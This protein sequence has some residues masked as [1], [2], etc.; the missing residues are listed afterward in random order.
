MQRRVWLWFAL[1]F[2]GLFLFVG[3]LTTRA[4]SVGPTVEDRVV[5]AA[6]IQLLL[7]GGDRFLAAD[8]EAIRSLAS[9]PGGGDDDALYRIRAHSAVA[10]LN[11]CHEDNYYTGNAL[12]TWGGAV[13]EGNDILLRAM[14]C[15]TWDEFP[16]FFYG[17]NQ[18]FF[19]R[20][21]EGARRAL[22]TAA[23]RANLNAAI[24][25]R[26]AIMI[27]AAT[28]P[29]ERMALAY[30]RQERNHTRDPNLQQMLDK[31]VIRLEGLLAIREAQRLFEQKFG[32][33][34]NTPEELIRSGIIDEIPTDPLKLGYEFK[35]GKFELRQLRIAGI[36]DER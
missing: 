34:L 21:Y 5:I 33:A 12:L 29:D 19:L 32:R 28:I 7:A 13:A 2:A 35:N 11:P 8:L 20:D 4:G 31:R 27:T 22:E 14:G 10:Q 17:F 16:A 26:V 30:L 1:I 3:S 23:Q 15:R 25:R 24:Y 6:P 18:Y 36:E 9:G